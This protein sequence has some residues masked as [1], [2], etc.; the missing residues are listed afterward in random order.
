MN[1]SLTK[2][3]RVSTFTWTI[4]Y[5]KGIVQREGGKTGAS[6][7]GNTSPSSDGLLFGLKHGIA[8]STC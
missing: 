2:R 7:R 3:N 1:E 5:S 8:D 6:R 4:R